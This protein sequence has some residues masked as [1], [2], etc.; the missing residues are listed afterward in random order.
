MEI[1]LTFA[2]LNLPAIL[3][4]AS[5]SFLFGGLWYGAL[6]NP[7]M[8]AAKITLESLKTHAAATIAPYVVAYLSQLVM[9]L[10]LAAM[11]G[12]L[13]A[14]HVTVFSG[15]MTSAALWIGFVITTMSVNYAF[16]GA[17]PVLTLIDGGHWLGVL[18]IQGAM[19]GWMGVG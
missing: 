19:L 8:D 5:A 13:G 14:G 15:A 4:A 10:F 18:L 9:A 7:W 6:A 3:V 17:R 2:G 1:P 12:R 11:L 16:H